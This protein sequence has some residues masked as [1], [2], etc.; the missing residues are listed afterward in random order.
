MLKSELI[1]LIKDMDDSTDIDEVVSPKYLNL[2]NIKTKSKDD[3]DIKSWLDSEKDKHS[4]KALE[5]WKNGTKGQEY[6]I[7]KFYELY[8]EKN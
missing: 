1:E 4:S 5:T 8:P 2:E 6:A 3:K 7:D